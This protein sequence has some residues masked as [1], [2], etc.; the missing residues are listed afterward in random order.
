MLGGGLEG[1]SS[2]PSRDSMDT[3]V[4]SD[5]ELQTFDL[6]NFGFFSPSFLWSFLT[7]ALLA[8]KRRTGLGRQHVKSQVN[9]S[10]ALQCRSPAA[11]A[12][13]IGITPRE[14]HQAFLCSVRQA[15]LL[16]LNSRQAQGGHQLLF[17]ILCNFY[18]QWNFSWDNDLVGCQ[19]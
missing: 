19:S 2:K 13:G 8:C 9:I 15:R 18:R 10:S 14:V 1:P 4:V 5:Y 11:C 16:H 6:I 17:S 7:A 12:P 3:D